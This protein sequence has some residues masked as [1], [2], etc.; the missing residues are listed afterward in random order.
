MYNMMCIQ[1][2]ICMYVPRYGVMLVHSV[3]CPAR[4]LV[5]GIC[6]IDTAYYKCVHAYMY[7][8]TCMYILYIKVHSNTYSPS[9]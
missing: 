1:M 4:I 7:V 3:V 2:V 9:V 8:C 5:S 6:Q